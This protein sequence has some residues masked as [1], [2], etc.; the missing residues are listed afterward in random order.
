MNIIAQKFENFGLRLA[1]SKTVTMTWNTTDDI[2]KM[3]SLISINGTEL[4]N[5]R[6]FRYLGHT[7]SN[8]PKPKFLSIQ[9]GLAYAAWNDHKKVLKD[10]RIKLWTRVKIAESLVRSRLTYAQDRLQVH[11][12]SK[13]DSIWLRFCRRMVKGGFRRKGTRDDENENSVHY[14]YTNERISEL[15]NTKPASVFCDAQHLRFIGHIARMENDVPQ[16]QWLFAK[17]ARHQKDQWI[18]LG[19]DWN[20]EPTQIR[21]TISKK[22]SVE[23]LLKATT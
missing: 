23:A 2:M 9:I 14:Y 18:M 6:D 5:L 13:I 7:L 15:C 17:Q 16:K 21:K 10:Q 4:K 11:E 19:R 8:E 20:M 1:E 3:E 12:K 22:E